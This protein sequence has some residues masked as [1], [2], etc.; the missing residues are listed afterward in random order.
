MTRDPTLDFLLADAKRLGLTPAE[1]EREFRV[2]LSDEGDR[3]SAAAQR[4]RRHERRSGLMG[5]D[6]ITIAKHSEKRRVLT[7]R[8]SRDVLPPND[9]D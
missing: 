8:F 6:D 4:I 2:I 3:P 7:R 1:Y 9:C 5:E